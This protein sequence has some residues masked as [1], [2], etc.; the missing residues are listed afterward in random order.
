MRLILQISLDRGVIPVLSTLPPLHRDWAIGRVEMLNGIIVALAREYDIP[1]W[2]YWSAL[3]G[4]PNDGLSTDGV[5]PSFYAGHAADFAPDY[6]GYGYTV[7]NLLAL[8]VLDAVW[9]A[10][11]Y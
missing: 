1:L 10:A 3:Q 9:R 2:D 7:R 8:Q 11:M 4:L 6:L 5:H